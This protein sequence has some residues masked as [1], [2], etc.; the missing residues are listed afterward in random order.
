MVKAFVSKFFAFFFAVEAEAR[1]EIELFEIAAV[2]TSLLFAHGPSKKARKYP[3][4]VNPAKFS[5]HVVWNH[6][7][8]IK[9]ASVAAYR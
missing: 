3:W 5:K 4:Q 2:E 8:G 6:S 7:G 9:A 1:F